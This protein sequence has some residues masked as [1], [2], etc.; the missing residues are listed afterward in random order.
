MKKEVDYG[1]K[2]DQAHFERD[3]YLE[4]SKNSS[5]LERLSKSLDLLRGIK[6]LIVGDTVIDRYTY[7]TPRGRA[8]K[9]PIL[10]SSFEFEEDYAGG[11]LAVANHV[12]SYVDEI[13]LVTL[14]GDQNPQLEFIKK[15][16]SK[17]IR[18]ETFIK[19]HSPTIIKQRYIDFKKRSEDGRI[20]F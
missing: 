3:S 13:K 5:R 15:S 17:N 14:L 18:L 1:H 2:K 11:V 9:D 8:T 6:V 4:D 10:S 20:W 19:T 16:L 12:S 7:V